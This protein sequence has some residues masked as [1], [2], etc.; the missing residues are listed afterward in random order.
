MVQITTLVESNYP[1]TLANCIY[2]NCSSFISTV[3]SIIKPAMSS[4]TFGRIRHFGVDRAIWVPV[5]LELVD[6][7]QLTPQFGGVKQT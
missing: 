6:P 5:V 1:E 7:T 4:R 2:I 3:L